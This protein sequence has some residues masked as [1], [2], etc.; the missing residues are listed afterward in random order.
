MYRYSVSRL[1]KNDPQQHGLQRVA[2]PE[3]HPDRIAMRKIDRM[4]LGL[5]WCYVEARQQ[6]PVARRER[7]ARS[8]KAWRFRQP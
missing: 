8:E 5:R 1:Q 2:L 4:P 3:Q 7:L 6:R